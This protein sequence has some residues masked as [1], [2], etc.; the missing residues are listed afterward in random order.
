MLDDD[1]NNNMNREAFS[2]QFNFFCFR[3]D[4]AQK[5]RAWASLIEC[6]CVAGPCDG[7]PA[8]KRLKQIAI[9]TLLNVSRNIRKAC[10]NFMF[11]E[12]EKSCVINGPTAAPTHNQSCNESL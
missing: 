4:I 7:S 1:D 12:H 11:E 6:A 2:F 10:T 5:T 9:T 3:R 8:Q